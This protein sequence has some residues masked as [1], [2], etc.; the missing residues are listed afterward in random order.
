LDWL[1]VLTALVLAALSTLLTAL[2]GLIGLILLAGF[3]LATLL[4]AALAAL[5]LLIGAF[6]CHVVLPLLPQS[7]IDQRFF[8][9]AVPFDGAEIMGKRRTLLREAKKKAEPFHVSASR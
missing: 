3:V 7:S 9:S 6:I 2:A 5:V 1:S 8:R 4:A